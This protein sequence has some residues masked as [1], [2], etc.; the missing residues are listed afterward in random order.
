MIRNSLK[1]LL[2]STVGMC[3]GLLMMTQSVWATTYSFKSAGN[4]GDEGVISGTVTYDK[5]QV[6]NALNSGKDLE[7]LMGSLTLADLGKNAT[8]SFEYTSPHTGVKHT[9]QTICNRNIYDLDNGQEGNYSIGGQEGPF[10]SFDSGGNLYLV[11]FKS[12]VGEEGGLASSISKRDP[13]IA[14]S[15]LDVQFSQYKLAEYDYIGNKPPRFI[16][17]NIK[18]KFDREIA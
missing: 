1:R 3:L 10:F 5:D 11:D 15:E 9:E 17:K 18:I 12:C 2:I 14:Y 8:F 13:K 16:Q 7:G 6:V 4:I